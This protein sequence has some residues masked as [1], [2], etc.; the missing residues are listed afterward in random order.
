MLDKLKEQLAGIYTK[1][2]LQELEDIE[3]LLEFKQFTSTD[4]F[5]LGSTI[6]KEAKKAG[7]DIIVFITNEIE[8][9]LMYQYIGE[10]MTQRNI[11]FANKKKNAVLKSGHCSLWPMI[12]ELVDGGQSEVFAKESDC[13][14]VGGAF[15]IYVNGTL[16]ATIA[17]SGLHDGMDFIVAVRALAAFHGVEEPVFHGK[18]I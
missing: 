1:Q 14:P 4:A 17:I 7:G 16:T 11:D 8:Q 15:P 9:S 5:L 2:H 12:K 13:L 3:R 18:C 10:K 6:A